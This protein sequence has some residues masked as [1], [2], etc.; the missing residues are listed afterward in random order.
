MTGLEILMAIVLVILIFSNAQIGSQVR[1]LKVEIEAHRLEIQRLASNETY[2]V[3]YK[4]PRPNV[5][6]DYWKD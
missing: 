5:S 1:K 6:P 4:L 3:G 2:A